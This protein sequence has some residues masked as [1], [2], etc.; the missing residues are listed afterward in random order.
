MNHLKVCKLKDVW[1]L[2]AI[3]NSVI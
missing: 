1:K 3:K 2:F